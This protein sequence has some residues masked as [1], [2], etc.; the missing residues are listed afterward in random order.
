MLLYADLFA[1]EEYQGSVCKLKALNGLK[2]S[3]REWLGKFSES[4]IEFVLHR[5]FS[6]IQTNAHILFVV[7]VDDI[8]NKGLL[9]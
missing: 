2:Q 4:I 5:S 7:F 6:L 9:D 3:M 1:K 8:V